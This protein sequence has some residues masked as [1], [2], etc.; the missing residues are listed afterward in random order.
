MACR[1][2]TT[3]SQL[4]FV[5]NVAWAHPKILKFWGSKMI[6]F[7]LCS[8]CNFDNFGPTMGRSIRRPG[9]SNVS[10]KSTSPKSNIRTT[11][12]RHTSFFENLVCTQCIGTRVRCFGASLRRFGARP[13]SFMTRVSRFGLRS[14]NVDAGVPTFGARVRRF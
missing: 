7:L 13:S 11:K 4:I 3:F 1:K 12:R 5:V 9:T 8:C 2:F 14:R 6:K 10:N